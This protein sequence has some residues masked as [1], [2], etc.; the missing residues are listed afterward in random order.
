MHRLELQDIL[1]KYPS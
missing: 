1:R